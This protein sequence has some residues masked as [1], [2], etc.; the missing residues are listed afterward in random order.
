MDAQLHVF[1]FKAGLLAR[2]AHDLR[3]TVQSFDVTL[4]NGHVDARFDLRSL[5]VD[6]VAHGEQVDAHT[7]PDRDKRTIE[8]TINHDILMT[9]TQPSASFAGQVRALGSQRYA[10]EGKLELRKTLRPLTLEVSVQRGALVA[11]ASLAPSDFGIAPYKALAGAIRLADRVELR[12]SAALGGRDPEALLHGTET[13][14]FTPSA[15]AV[16]ASG[17]AH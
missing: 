2:L 1:T 11:T 7:L 6:G 16:A 3:L 12:F 9:G 5:M 4:L 13:L 10:V 17:P 8:Q 14:H 15:G